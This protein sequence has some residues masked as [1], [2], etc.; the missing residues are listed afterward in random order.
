MRRLPASLL[1][2]LVLLLAPGANGADGHPGEAVYLRH[3]HRCHGESGAG[4]E[5]VPEALVGERSVGQLAAIIDETMPEDDPALVSAEESRQVAEWIHATFYSTLARDRNRPA[6]VE[7][8]RLTVG[9]HR[10]AIADLVAGFAGPVPPATAERGLRGQ[11]YR[12]RDFDDRRRVFERVDPEVGFDFGVEGPDPERFE[13]GRFAIRWHGAVVP[14]ESGP[15]EFVVRTGHATRL[16]VNHPDWNGPALIDAL[17]KSGDDSEYRGTIHLLAG[18]A[19]PLRLEF[20]KASQ[21]VDDARHEHPCR[22]S[23]ELL[24][25]PP[26]GVLERVPSRCLLPLDAPPTYVVTTPFPPDDR[27]I[28]Y[29]RGGSVSKEWLEAVEAAA[30]ETADAVRDRI[31]RLAGVRPDAPDRGDRLRAFAADFA[32][33]AFRRPLDAGQRARYVDRPF[34]EAPDA[35][36]AIAR[37][38]LLALSSPRFLFR[39]PADADPWHTASRLSFAL[40]D[41]LPDQTLLDAA[42][43]GELDTPERIEAQVRRM[44]LD[45]RARSKIDDFLLGWTRIDLAPEAAKDQSRYPGFGPDTAAD[46]RT[47]LRLFLDDVAFPAPL[48]GP[49]GGTPSADFRRLFTADEVWINGRLAPLYGVELPPG[50]GFRPV[51]LDGGRRAGVLTHPALLSVLAYSGGSSPIHRGVFLV[52]GVL[53]NV[54]EPPAEAVAPLA[55]DLHPGLSTRQ[56]VTIQTSPVACQV[57]HSLINPL[58]FALEDWDGIGRLRTEDGTGP[59][60]ASG[61]Y[62]PRHGEP[63]SFDGARELGEWVASSRDA[64]EAFLQALFHALVKQPMRAWGPDVPDRL[65]AAFEARG[66]DIREAVVD[67]MKVAAFPPPPA[68]NQPG[69]S[70]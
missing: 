53:G 59:V 32:E 36:T 54:L 55:T 34:A 42:A 28:G 5:R 61:S 68:G 26:H 45:R 63:V 8:T 40:W 1:P 20:S 49:D 3:C 48:G 15:H 46:L 50:A 9:Q 66:R 7:L 14:T 33:R 22:A 41:S 16:L 65:G 37:A 17:V 70:R 39:E 64:R 44:L 47:S 2:G 12:G 6:R 57:C 18:R 56:R 69:E 4:T 21:G 31:D 35:D 13:P 30:A 10:G 38:V 52:R 43:R 25:K 58:G 24:W 67:I 11:Y 19:Y 51:R 29:E 23:I 60:D 62:V 27:S